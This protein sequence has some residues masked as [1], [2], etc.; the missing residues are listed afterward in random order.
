MP[1]SAREGARRA[2]RHHVGLGAAVGEAHA[3]ERGKARAQ[4]RG[5]LA[6]PLSDGREIEAPIDGG[7]QGGL[8][9]RLGVAEQARRV[10]AAEVD[11]ALPVHVLEEAALAPRHR[12]RKRRVEQHRARVA[13]G[14]N[15]TCALMDAGALGPGGRIPLS[16][17]GQ[18]RLETAVSPGVRHVRPPLPRA[19]RECRQRCA[20]GPGTHDLPARGCRG[21]GR[22]AHTR[23]SRAP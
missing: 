3:L 1:A 2:Q 23:A 17:I 18:S 16:G 11:V 9:A 8:D 15:G 5:E 7:V 6:L 12:C 10:L 14:Q 20:C 22:S 13:A 21:S 4:Q 19:P